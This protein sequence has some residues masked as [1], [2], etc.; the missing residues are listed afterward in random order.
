MV[1]GAVPPL[2]TSSINQPLTS[3]SAPPALWSSTQPEFP[4]ENSLMVTSAAEGATQL[5]LSQVPV[6]HALPFGS[7]LPP[8]QAQ[9]AS[10]T[11]PV[12]Q[13]FPSS[14]A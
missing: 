6:G 10:N 3:A 13:G 4:P 14:Q 5:P 7:A 11:S 1:F 8:V 12:V 9:L 2:A